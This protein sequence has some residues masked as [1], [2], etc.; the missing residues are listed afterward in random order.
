M[1][2]LQ[3]LVLCCR[4]FIKGIRQRICY[5]FLKPGMGMSRKLIKWFKSVC[6]H[7]I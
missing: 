2:D 4:T 6:F 1:V 3:M 7:L 5:A